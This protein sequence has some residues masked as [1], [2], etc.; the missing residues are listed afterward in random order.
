MRYFIGFF[1]NIKFSK[2]AVEFV[3]I[4]HLS[5]GTFRVLSNHVWTVA[6]LLNTLALSNEFCVCVYVCV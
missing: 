3:F 2:F 1:Y 6:I 4:A 5:S